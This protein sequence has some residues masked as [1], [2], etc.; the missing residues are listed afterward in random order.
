MKN[1]L[2]VSLALAFCFSLSAAG[3]Q[4]TIGQWQ[5]G[6]NLP[7]FPVHMHTTQTGK[8]IIWPGDGGVSGN[9]PAYLTQLTEVLHLWPLRDMTYSAA[10]TAFFQMDG[11]SLRVVTLATTSVSPRPQFTT[12]RTMCGSVNRI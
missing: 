3:Q 1:F 11:S 12:Q 10:G 9:D 7:F 5:N 4:A 6:P 8:L 2:F